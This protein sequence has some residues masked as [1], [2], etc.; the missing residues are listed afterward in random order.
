M[1][2]ELIKEYFE[3]IT[4]KLENLNNSLKENK[5]ENSLRLAHN[6]KGTTAAL[7]LKSLASLFL[8]LEEAIST[9]DLPYIYNLSNQIKISIDQHKELLS[10]Y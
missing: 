10:Y 5:K 9:E 8:S 7:H 4:V 6:I 2:L 3:G 1:T